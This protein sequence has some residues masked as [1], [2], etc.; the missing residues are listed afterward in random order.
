MTINLTVRAEKDQ[1]SRLVVVS[2]SDINHMREP[3][4][5]VSVASGHIALRQTS[6]QK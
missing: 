2:G 1:G 3:F 6:R 4:R 5:E